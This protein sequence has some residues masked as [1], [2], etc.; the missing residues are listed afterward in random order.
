MLGMNLMVWFKKLW[1]RIFC[2]PAKESEEEEIKARIRQLE[3]KAE[4]DA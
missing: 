1:V 4:T 2:K 3:R